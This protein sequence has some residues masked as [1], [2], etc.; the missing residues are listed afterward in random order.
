[1]RVIPAI[2]TALMA[3]ALAAATSEVPPQRID[4]LPAVPDAHGFA[5]AVAGVHRGHLL[6][7]GGANFPGGLMP[8]EGGKKVWH[9]RVFGFAP[10]RGAAW[11]QI[12]R[13]PAPN[14]YGVSLT[15]PDG[16]LIIGGGN[17]ARNFSDVWLMTITGQSLAF[18]A[19]A[20]LP[21]PLA[22]MAGA[23]GG[24]GVH[25]IGGAQTPDA[26]AASVR[27]YRLELD[28]IDG[29]WREMP[30]LPAPGRI[31]AMAAGVANAFY[32][33]GGCALAA[34]VDGK[35]VRTY[36]R[37]A[38]RF[39]DG[40]WTRVAD[41]PTPLAASPSP[42]PVFEHDIYLLS[43]DDG[44]QVA[45]KSP[46]QHKGFSRQILRYDTIENS[47]QHA[48]DLGFPGP[49]TLPATP[50][51]DGFVLFN[52]E[53]RPGVRTTRVLLFRATR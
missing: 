25:I 42:A 15:I 31:L 30:E 22:Q 39:S 35:P 41:L 13:L 24:G 38:W 7:G 27:H 45:L 53:I 18:R 46:A 26:S 33:M 8:W 6:A 1:V 12:G 3:T 23:T 36:L 9:D 20:P 37:D 49:V 14:A 32:V 5:G 44:S 28:A 29:G 4:S 10:D 40:K 17:A 43:G 48:G 52:G 51:K 19:L 11:R 47:W 2:G 16:V 21:V 50:W 34:D